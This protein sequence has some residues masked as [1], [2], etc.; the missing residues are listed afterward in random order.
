MK[1]SGS[2]HFY[3]GVFYLLIS[4]VNPLC[5]VVLITKCN[6]YRI[7]RWKFLPSR[8]SS[9]KKKKPDRRAVKSGSKLP[10]GVPGAPNYFTNTPD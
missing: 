5:W 4:N 6:C 10:P 3:G 8:P 1:Q 2:L 7:N 9:I